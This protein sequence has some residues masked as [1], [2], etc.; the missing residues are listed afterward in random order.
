MFDSWINGDY[1]SRDDLRADCWLLEE[2]DI[3]DAGFYMGTSSSARR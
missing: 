2:S 3:F 1:R